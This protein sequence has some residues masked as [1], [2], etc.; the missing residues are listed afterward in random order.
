MK[1]ATPLA[2]ADPGRPRFKL[3]R[4]L[5]QSSFQNQYGKEAALNTQCT[6]PKGRTTLQTVNVVAVFFCQAKGLPAVSPGFNL[7]L[8]LEHALDSSRTTVLLSVHHLRTPRVWPRYPV[9]NM[10]VVRSFSSPTTAVAATAGP[11]SEA[12][13]AHHPCPFGGGGFRIEPTPPAVPNRPR[14]ARKTL[15]LADTPR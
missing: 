5:R 12:V 7:P 3:V 6:K 10:Q 14:L 11:P 1:R 13:P 15:G 9:Q 2:T 4:L 8:A